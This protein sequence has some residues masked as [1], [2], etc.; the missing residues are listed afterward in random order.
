VDKSKDVGKD[1]GIKGVPVFVLF[2]DGK[3]VSRKT[4]LLSTEELRKFILQ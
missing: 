1:Y 4:G 2:K 3:E